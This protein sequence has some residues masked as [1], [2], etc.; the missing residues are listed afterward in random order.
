M[1]N[2]VKIFTNSNESGD[3]FVVQKGNKAIAQGHSIS[4]SD[5]VD[6]LRDLGVNAIRQD[7]TDDELN[8]IMRVLI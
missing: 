3:Y 7:C 1:E 5:L 8:S 6:I 4:V 2:E